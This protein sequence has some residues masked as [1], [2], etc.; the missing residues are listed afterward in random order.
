MIR[1]LRR[2]T[3]DEGPLYGLGVFRAVVGFMVIRDAWGYLQKYADRGFFRDEFHL[4]YSAWYPQPSEPVY[5][6]VLL[7]LVLSGVC[8]VVGVWI[9]PAVVVTC[10]LHAYHLFLNQLWYRHNRYFLVLSLVLL[11]FSPCS[12]TFS[13]VRARDS[14]VGPLWASFLIR[15]Q[16]SLIYLASAISKTLDPDWSSG[17]VLY[18]RGVLETWDH[19]APL[20]LHEAL[21]RTLLVQ[22]MTVA[23]LGQEFF[24]G[25]FL[26]IPRTRRL[27]MWVGIVFHTYIELRH[28]VLTFS[29]LVL[30][31]YFLFV[32]PTVQDRV[33]Y[34]PRGSKWLERC[35]HTVMFLDWLKK[36]RVVDYSGARVR[37]R[38][39]DGR[40]YQGWF[41]GIIV[42]T[43][44]PLLFF[45]SYPL[46][47]VR[48]FAR[49]VEVGEPADPS[50]AALAPM[51]AAHTVMDLGF[52]VL[53]YLGIVWS[54]TAYHV[55][56]ASRE[57]FKWW[58]I[59]LVALMLCLVNQASRQ[60]GG[61]PE[62]RP[63]L[64]PS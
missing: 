44:L 39:F 60:S 33:M 52:V 55:P 56:Y 17:R 51:A 32:R 62:V 42:G 25:I 59:P 61:S 12:R 4:P 26:W 5:L 16:L 15:A 28:S 48:I 36:V 27:A 49:G 58:D 10:V 14:P 6:S 45:V 57:T 11:C 29:Y 21:P 1:R 7:L 34:I 2:W 31:A 37:V 8:L 46:S 22:W 30:A 13:I 47:V 20:W 9:R 23:A 63:S 43:A 41:A 3:E 50:E 53:L 24:L 54:I 19:I 40:V 64:S 35:G 38:D 18:D